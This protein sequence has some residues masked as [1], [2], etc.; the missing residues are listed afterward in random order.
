MQEPTPL[1]EFRLVNLCR[2]MF[3]ILI[4]PIKSL[5]NEN[6]IR[7]IAISPPGGMTHLPFEALFDNTSANAL[8]DSFNILYLPS[9]RIGAD[10]VDSVAS[11]THGKLLA[12]AYADK[13]LPHTK[14]EIE[15]LRQV[16]KDR[17]VLLDGERC[18]KRQVME[19]LK[20][21][22]D[23]LH[24][25]CHGSFDVL[26]P[27]NSALHLVANPQR[28]SQRL[29]AHDILSVKFPSRPIVTMSACS[30]ALT[31]A[32]KANDYIGLTGSLL[33]AG[34]RAIIGSRWPVYDDTAA[35]FMIRF[36][37]KLYNANQG[38][39]ENFVD[40]QKEMRKS[41]NVE[42]WAAFGYLGLP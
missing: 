13:D 26:E 3:E 22:Y 1:R 39:Y 32:T 29:T 35:D 24:F 28:D 16:W 14:R 7:R 2:T 19:E 10:L 37:E 34:A 17:M 11:N 30:T 20:N 8:A 23:Y 18:T 4:S 36:Y 21:N 41:C 27:L 15:S 6:G 33:R 38:P 9:I 42:D 31:A 40:V 5:L 12:V 25:S